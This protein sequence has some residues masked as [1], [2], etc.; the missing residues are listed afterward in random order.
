M[1]NT[2][3]KNAKKTK[4]YA[5]KNLPAGKAAAIVAKTVASEVMTLF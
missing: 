1:L 2:F 4:E 3:L 5:T